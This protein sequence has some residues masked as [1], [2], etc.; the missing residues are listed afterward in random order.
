MENR[1]YTSFVDLNIFRR[2][3]QLPFVTSGGL[4]VKYA[5]DMQMNELKQ[6]SVILSGPRGANPWLELYE[7]ELNFIGSNNGVPPTHTFLNRPPPTH[8]PAQSPQPTKPP[9]HTHS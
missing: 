9:N 3:Q 6:S 2:L 4:E 1:R 8:P 5:R 7:P